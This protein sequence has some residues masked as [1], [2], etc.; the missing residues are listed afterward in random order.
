MS[1]EELEASLRTY[2]RRRPFRPYLLEFVSGAQ[3]RIENRESIAFFTSFWL[4]RGPRKAQA[5]FTSSSVY[6]L[7]DIPPEKE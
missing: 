3:V 2:N 4:Y 7:L 5:L 6:R 1:N